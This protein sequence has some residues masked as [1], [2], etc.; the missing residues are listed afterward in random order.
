MNYILA[1]TTGEKFII[2]KQE[3]E[4]IVKAGDMITIKRLGLMVQKRMVQVYPQNHPDMIDDRK[5]QQTGILHDGSR[6][7]RHFGQWV[8][9]TGLIP[10]D[11][12]NY[13]PVKLDTEYYPE[14][15]TDCLA[16]EEE[17]N[18]MQKDG[19]DYYLFLGINKKIKSYNAGF[20]HLLN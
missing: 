18:Q 8:A 19:K 10:D 9:D 7:I 13:K 15:A 11:N 6:A 20:T 12:G 16:T 3:A 17:Y 5:K 2:N 4:N 14:I 1:L